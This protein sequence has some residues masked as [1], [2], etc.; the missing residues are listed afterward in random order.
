MLARAYER[1]DK[2]QARIDIYEY[3]RP[4]VDFHRFTVDH[5]ELRGGERVLDVGCGTATA[6]RL[7]AAREE[8]LT[9]VGLDRSAGMLAQSQAGDRSGRI[10]WVAGDVGALPAPAGAYDVVLA[11][12]MLYHAADVDRAVRELRRVLRGGGTLLATTLGRDHMAELHDLATEALAGARL[13]RPS[14]RFGIDN[15]VFLRRHFRS[16]SLDRLQGELVLESPGPLVRYLDSARDL[17][18]PGLP[19]GISW[20]DTLAHVEARIAD[21]IAADGTFRVTTDSGVFTCT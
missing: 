6:L 8:P 10:R 7:L 2:L 13:D 1:G 4:Q 19:A 16:V 11:M 15:H 14:F 12:H 18:E 20:S 17:F 21:Q 5:L 3:Q 9:L